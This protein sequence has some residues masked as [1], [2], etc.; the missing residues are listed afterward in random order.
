[1]NVGLPTRRVLSVCTGG[2]GLDRGLHAAERGAR[3]ICSVEIEAFAVAVLAAQI[4][5][6]ALA[7]F[8][9]WT[10]A[11][12]FDGAAWR[13]AV[14]IGVAGFPCQDISSAGKRAG[15]HGER[16]G[17]WFDVARI[18]C[19]VGCPV[20]FLENVD[21]LTIRGIDTVLGT[22]A[23]SGLHAVWDVFSAAEVGAPHLRDR[24]FCLAVA[25]SSDRRWRE[26]RESSGSTGQPDGN[27][28]AVDDT[29]TR[30]RRGQGNDVRPGR[31]RPGRTCADVGN[32]DGRNR[33][34]GWSPVAKGSPA[35]LLKHAGGRL[36]SVGATSPALADANGHGRTQQRSLSGATGS[37]HADGRERPSAELG[38]FPPGRDDWRAWGRVVEQDPL[39]APALT[40]SQIRRMADGVALGSRTDWLR[41]LGNGV[42]PQ[43]AEHAYRVLRGRLME[44]GLWPWEI[45]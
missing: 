31:D 24:W 7:P 44:A 28:Q 2:A 34:P 40:Q 43:Q 5:A 16:S 13:G 10:D 4:E 3:T 42:V 20:W 22:L 17:L 14:D 9:I 19:D 41:L 1:M 27:R 25:H 12:T 39:L 21:D 29:D 6:E 11:R 15:I 30:R 35:G 36:A 45:A 8:P 33:R 38:A 32:A 37:D 23:E 26:L 18:F